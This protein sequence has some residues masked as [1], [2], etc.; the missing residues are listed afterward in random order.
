MTDHY[1]TQTAARHYPN[2]P[3]VIPYEGQTAWF[4]RPAGFPRWP[5]G[6]PGW[7]ASS[8]KT[9]LACIVPTYIFMYVGRRRYIF[10][11]EREH[12][13]YRRLPTQ[14]GSIV[15]DVP[16]NKNLFLFAAAKKSHFR[17]TAPETNSSTAAPAMAL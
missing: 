9:G 15:G 6:L 10:G 17:P 14:V 1:L 5:T 2:W 7:L 12:S 11:D 4:V 13:T 3:K 16:W 8:F